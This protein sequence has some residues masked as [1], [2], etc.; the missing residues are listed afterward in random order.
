MPSGALRSLLATAPDEWRATPFYKMMLRGGEPDRVLAWGRDFR[1]GEFGRGMDIVRGSWRLGG[2]RLVGMYP[3][4]WAA[5][6][7]SKHFAAR[8]HGFEWLIDVESV[9]VAGREAASA[10]VHAWVEAFGRDFHASAWAP[11]LVADR[12]YAWL[13]HGR[14][15]FEDDDPIR[16][17]E[18]LRSYGRQ[19]RHLALALNDIRA[20]LSRVKAGAALVL[21][22]LSGLPDGDRLRELGEE[23]L[24]EACAAQILSDGGHA[25]RAP[26]LLFRVFCDFRTVDEALPRQGFET[27]RLIADALPRMAAMLRFFL[28]SDGGLAAFNGGGEGVPASIAAALAGARSGRS[29]E[30]ATQSGYQRLAAGDATLLMDVGS[31]PPAQFGERAHAG[32]LAFEFSAGPARIIVNVGSDYGLPPG[33]RAAGRPTNG[34][35]TLVVDDALSATFQQR[36]GRGAVVPVGPNVV[37]KR[38]AEDEGALIEANHDGYR[39]AYGYIHRRSLYFS[40]DGARLWGQDAIALPLSGGKNTPSPAPFSVRFHIH[41]AVKI[42]RS[43]IH[44]ITL[45]PERG[46]PWR[47]ATDARRLEVEPSIHLSRGQTA[48]RTRQ[49]V[50]YGVTEPSVPEDKPPNVVKWKFS[51][52]R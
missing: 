11:E 50:L 25:A 1:M 52:V 22:G 28:M 19:A 32:A 4:P 20:P 38:T 27:P 47:F 16:R 6:P 23:T 40:A 18:L 49:I 51:R 43:D 48:Q 24:E 17:V 2:E 10:L 3:S 36:R 12:L 26:E 42:E 14:A 5:R 41:P 31:A 15:A 45:T 29:F 30:F 46:V 34:H 37:Q 7:P 44:E 39:A 33:W 35:S 8:L 21:A 9:G 13:C